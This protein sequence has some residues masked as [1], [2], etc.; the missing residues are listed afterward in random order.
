[1]T[2][3]IFHRVGQEAYRNTLN[4]KDLQNLLSTLVPSCIFSQALKEQILISWQSYSKFW[5]NVGKKKIT[6]IQQHSF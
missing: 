1:M 3:I 4:F 6:K 2:R 5:M